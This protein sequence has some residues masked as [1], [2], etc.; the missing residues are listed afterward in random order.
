MWNQ[1][2]AETC[3]LGD[4]RSPRTDPSQRRSRS[5]GLH[6]FRFVTAHLD[7]IVQAY[8]PA[9]MHQTLKR[10]RSD[11]GTNRLEFES[12]RPDRPGESNRDHD[13]DAE[14]DHMLEIDEAHMPAQHQT[15]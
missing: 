7:P 2:I 6:A 1:L 9:Q 15:E 4:L 5:A 8:R 10:H 11:L 13:A 14:C 3:G 12:C